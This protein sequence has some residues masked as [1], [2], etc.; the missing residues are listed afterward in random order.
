MAGRTNQKQRTRQA[1]IDAAKT[2]AANGR[3][4]TIAEGRSICRPASTSGQMLKPQ[5]GLARCGSRTRAQAGPTREPTRSVVSRAPDQHPTC[6]RADPVESAPFC[7]KPTR[8][9]ASHTSTPILNVGVVTFEGVEYPASTS[10]SS[11]RVCGTRSS[12]FVKHA[13][14]AQETLVAA[15]LNLCRRPHDMELARVREPQAI[16]FRPAGLSVR[17]PLG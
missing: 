9:L 7:V 10:R 16:R 2:L 12:R 4:L 6:F 1:L 14:R 17:A 5:P 15:A 11:L 3:R 8:T 13:S